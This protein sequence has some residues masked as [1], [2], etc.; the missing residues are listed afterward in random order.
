MQ[1]A[2]LI[3]PV[4]F[5][6]QSKYEVEKN[7]A[8]LCVACKPTSYMSIST[9]LIRLLRCE[10]LW[11]IL[12]LEVMHNFT[13]FIDYNSWISWVQTS[14]KCKLCGWTMGALLVH[15]LWY[16]WQHVPAAC[17]QSKRCLLHPRISPLYT[18]AEKFKL[19]KSMISHPFGN[20]LHMTSLKFC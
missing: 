3:Y 5:Y 12:I 10:H 7:N 11:H 13:K 17:S 4:Y 16:F 1:W 9:F 6:N 2:V 15:P 20:L 19:M 8:D 14:G 18:D